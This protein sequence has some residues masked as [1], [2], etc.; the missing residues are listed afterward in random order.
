MSKL[1]ESLARWIEEVE[2]GERK[3]P[4]KYEFDRIKKIVD[5]SSTTED[6][7][8]ED[9]VVEEPKIEDMTEEMNVS[10]LRDRASELNIEGRSGMNKADL[11]AAI[12]KA[13]GDD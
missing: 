8:V 4:S 3:A 12:N 5:E 11:I 9:E 13:E 6:E 7:V 10:E 2:S 1:I